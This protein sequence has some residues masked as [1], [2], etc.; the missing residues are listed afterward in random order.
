VG[1]G[2]KLV[3]D[4]QP[5]AYFAQIER[6]DTHGPGVSTTIPASRMARCIAWNEL[7]PFLA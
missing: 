7:S 4:G 2:S 3:A 6:R 5:D 1:Q